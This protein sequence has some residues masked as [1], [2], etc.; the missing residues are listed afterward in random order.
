VQ[1]GAGSEKQKM[2]SGVLLMHPGCL[3]ST[4]KTTSLYDATGVSLK[5]LN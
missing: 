2:C 5:V 4:I 1:K 3:D